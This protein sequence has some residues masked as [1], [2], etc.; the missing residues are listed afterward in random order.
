MVRILRGN[1]ESIHVEGGAVMTPT[2]ATFGN[3]A[4]GQTSG[5]WYYEILIRSTQQLLDVILIKLQV[6]WIRCAV[7]FT[8]YS[9]SIGVK[10]IHPLE[11]VLIRLTPYQKEH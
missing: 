2:F 5:K 3:P 8:L 9:A 1:A 11:G 7:H 4:L 10:N 6:Y